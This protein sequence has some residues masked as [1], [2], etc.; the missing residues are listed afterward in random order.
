MNRWSPRGDLFWLAFFGA[1][2]VILLAIV[3]VM[4]PVAAR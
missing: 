3:H 2:T 4:A 1:S